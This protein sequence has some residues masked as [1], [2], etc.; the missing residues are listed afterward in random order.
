MAGPFGT[1]LG[2]GCHE[3]QLLAFQVLTRYQ[4]IQVMIS[5]KFKDGVGASKVAGDEYVL[6]PTGQCS[7][8]LSEDDAL[9]PGQ[10]I[11]MAMTISFFELAGTDQCPQPT[12]NAPIATNL[13]VGEVRW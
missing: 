6:Y 11:S 12:C 8:T 3:T 1:Q 7:S 2:R 10:R 5:K 13:H 4:I 9:L